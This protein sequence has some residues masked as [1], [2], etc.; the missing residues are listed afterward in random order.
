MAALV[1]RAGSMP[2]EDDSPLIVL[3]YM[4]QFSPCLSLDA[5]GCL[6]LLGRRVHG[7]VNDR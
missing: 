6:H 5:T 4:C 1:G 2:Q 7:V 3:G